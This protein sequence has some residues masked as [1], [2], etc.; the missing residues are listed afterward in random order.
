[1][2]Q[3]DY[4]NEFE[5]FSQL[6]KPDI[7]STLNDYLTFNL[8]DPRH[9]LE[10]A[11]KYSIGT[12]AKRVR[13]LLMIAVY[14]MFTKEIKKILPL[15]CAIE[16]IHTYSLIHDDLPSMD[17]DDFRRG[18]LT[19]HKK[20]GEDIAIL[21]G[22][23]LNTYAFE[24]IARE[25]PRFYAPEKV[26]SVIQILAENCGIKGMAGGQVLDL[27]SPV[28]KSDNKQLIKIHLL[29]TGALIKACVVLP[30]LLE[31]NNQ[32]IHN[33]LT[34]MGK[35]IGLLFQIVDDILDV[36]GEPDVMG[37]SLDKDEKQNKL[38]YV[39]LFGLEQAQKLAEKEAEK[40]L[41]ILAKCE[42]LNTD[43]LKNM[44]LYLRDRVC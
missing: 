15:A 43:T 32:V 19:C 8:T 10:Q 41:S 4:K 16:M 14:L 1:M 27:K 31:N 9:A 35:S 3:T 2:T 29:K 18:Q 5:T 30:S 38:T 17:N 44:I 39:R 36:Q 25:L 24:I 13:P 20:F 34:D 22:D 42:S 40:A 23:T 33:Q 7:E 26:I 12:K 28:G 37:K 11:V 21:A 6:Y